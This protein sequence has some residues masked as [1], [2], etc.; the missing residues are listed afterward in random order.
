MA[1]ISFEGVIYLSHYNCL[2]MPI[3]HSHKPH[4][5]FFPL[6]GLIISS[7][8]VANKIGAWKP[9]DPK[10]L[11]Y[12]STLTE[13]SW[14]GEI[15][16]T[17]LENIV[18]LSNLASAPPSPQVSQPKDIGAGDQGESNR[19]DDTF[20]SLPDMISLYLLHLLLFPDGSRSS[21]GPSFGNSQSVRFSCRLSFPQ[22]WPIR[23]SSAWTLRYSRCNQFVDLNLGDVATNTRRRTGKEDLKQ[24]YRIDTL[25]HIRCTDIAPAPYNHY[26]STPTAALWPSFLVV[27]SSL[28]CT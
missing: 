22:D 2:S 10:T 20:L 9:K 19:V 4:A 8:S 21:S 28:F 13:G 27:K 25:L 15:T 7:L 1:E 6:V 26:Y 17:L 14:L 16:C 23:E 3:I 24:H 18:K 12:A 5:N 11:E